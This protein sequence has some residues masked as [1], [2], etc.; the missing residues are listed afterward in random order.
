MEVIV[1]DNDTEHFGRV[2]DCREDPEG[3]IYSPEVIEKDKI[4]SVEAHK[5]AI[6]KTRHKKLGFII[7]PYTNGTNQE[8]EK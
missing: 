3:M 2:W 8:A 4:D 7:Q 1:E 5:K 6:T